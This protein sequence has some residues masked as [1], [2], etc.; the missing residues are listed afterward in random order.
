M[1]KLKENADM[2][3]MIGFV[4][5]VIGVIVTSSNKEGFFHA[6]GITQICIGVVVMFSAGILASRYPH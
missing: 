1:K 6:F 3:F 2:I 5:H 4:L